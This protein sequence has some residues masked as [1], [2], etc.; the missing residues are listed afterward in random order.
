VVS[1]N[2]ALRYRTLRL[3]RLLRLLAGCVRRVCLRR[4]APF[5]IPKWCVTLSLTHSTFATFARVR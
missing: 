4:N 1:R 2:G 3:L 5:G